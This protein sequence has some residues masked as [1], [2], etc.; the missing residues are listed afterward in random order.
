MFFQML[1]NSI[2]KINGLNVE[3]EEKIVKSNKEIL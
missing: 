2:N 1:V 3:I